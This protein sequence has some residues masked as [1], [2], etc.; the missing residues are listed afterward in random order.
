M[1]RSSSALAAVDATIANAAAIA[2]R[3]TVRPMF[4]IVMASRRRVYSYN[5]RPMRTSRHFLRASVLAGVTLIASTVGAQQPAGAAGGDVK[6]TPGELIVE[7][8]T[9][10]NLGFEWRVG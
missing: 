8:P 4:L 6:V 2:S 5:P 7:H 3:T 10:I 9:L 1:T